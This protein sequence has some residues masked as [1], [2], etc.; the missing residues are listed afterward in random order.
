MGFLELYLRTLQTLNTQHTRDYK[1]S[2]D[3]RAGVTPLPI[4]NR[5]VKLR[6]ADGTTTAGLWES[7]SSPDLF[8]N[9][10]WIYSG[11]SFFIFC[12]VIPAEAGILR[13]KIKSPQH[14]DTEAQRKS[15]AA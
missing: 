11:W 14:R 9:S 15:K 5:E 6:L 12:F 1:V 13:I 10:N 2:G 4:S 3:Y 7:R 8:L